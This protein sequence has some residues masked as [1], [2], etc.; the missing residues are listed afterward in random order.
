MNRQELKK[1]Q[2]EMKRS[3]S[4]EVMKTAFSMFGGD[5]LMWNHANGVKI[6]HAVNASSRV[7]NFSENKMIYDITAPMQMGKSTATMTMIAELMKLNTDKDFIIC[8]Y[9]CT[10]NKSVV[11]QFRNEAQHF[12]KSLNHFDLSSTDEY[13]SIFCGEQ[14]TKII[15]VHNTSSTSLKKRAIAHIGSWDDDDTVK[16]LLFDEADQALGRDSKRDQFLQKVLGLENAYGPQAMTV[17]QNKQLIE[18]WI[19]ATNFFNYYKGITH[20][21]KMYSRIDL[22]EHPD[23]WSLLKMMLHGYVFEK[24]ENDIKDVLEKF[25]NSSQE[26]EQY[27]RPVAFVRIKNGNKESEN[28]Y[29][30]N[31]LNNVGRRCA[32]TTDYNEFSLL[33]SD[34]QTEVIAIHFNGDK[35]FSHCNLET[36]LRELDCKTRMSKKQNANFKKLRKKIVVIICGTLKEGNSILNKNSNKISLLWESITEKTK[37]FEGPL[38]QA[39]RICKIGTEDPPLLFA[40]KKLIGVLQ[41]YIHEHILPDGE[42]IRWTKNK[43]KVALEGVKKAF[44]MKEDGFKNHIEAR[45]HAKIKSM[46]LGIEIAI[47]YGSF[48]KTDHQEQYRNRIYPAVKYWFEGDF[49]DKDQISIIHTAGKSNS[50]DGICYV[51]ELS[52]ENFGYRLIYLIGDIDD[53]YIQNYA[54]I[55]CDKC[56]LMKYEPSSDNINV[57]ESESKLSMLSVV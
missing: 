50:C 19:G 28:F 23:Y 48:K 52:P 29:K 27:S 22:L 33:K 35:T 53:E 41:K 2:D 32:F 25:C 18:F 24:E 43:N 12:F 13:L 10:S 14:T 49:I 40:S 8:Y 26:Y 39:G 16:I 7:F 21:E 9:L 38:Q 17:R 42:R 44:F 36:L 30:E 31:I 15:F 54:D 47:R 11:D 5:R 34:G 51:E 3:F 55:N 56:S 45:K 1:E 4:R 20:F 46:E 6:A 37:K 57:M